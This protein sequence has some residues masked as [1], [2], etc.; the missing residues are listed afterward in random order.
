MMKMQVTKNGG[1]DYFN[2]LLSYFKQQFREPIVKM[3]RI[4]DSVYI[5]KTMTKKYVVKGYSKYK[6]LR[7]QETFTETLHQ[8][9]FKKTYHF[10]QDITKEPLFFEGEYF[11]CMEFLEPARK[12]FTFHSHKNRKEGLKLLEE[13]HQ[14]TATCVS[15]YNTLLPY[16]DLLGKWEARLNSFKK[17]S[18]KI[19][20]Q[21]NEQN[22][23]ELLDWAQWSLNGMKANE[24]FYSRQPHCILHGDV[25]HHNFLRD[26]S[27]TLHLIDFDLAHI[28]SPSI[29]YLQYAN[30]IL[31]SIDWSFDE[32]S[33]YRQIQ[34]L[35]KEKGFLYALAFPTDIFREWNR[36]MRE[37]KYTRQYYYN[38]VVELTLDQFSLRRK[39]FEKIKKN[40]EDKGS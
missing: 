8:E 7:L 11:G 1:D 40:V 6:K 15:R 13:F 29:D 22:V 30:R 5:V 38:N 14:V 37:K 26:T 36:M 17:Y 4:R 24:N 39:L 20:Y 9:G 12:D 19:C 31:P 25:A 21:I 35:L 27:D 34:G 28:G 3:E 10:F 16:S 2:R 33:K 32:L 18:P 23:N